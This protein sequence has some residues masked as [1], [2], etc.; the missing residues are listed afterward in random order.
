MVQVAKDPIGTKG[1][2][3]P[4]TSRSPAGT[5]CSCR[6]SITSASRRRIEHE[7][8]RRRL[9]DIRRRYRPPGTGF[10]VRTVAENVAEREARGR[11]P[12]P[13]RGLERRSRREGEPPRRRR[14]CTS[15]R[16]SCASSRPLPRRRGAHGRRQPRSSTRT[17]CSFVDEFSAGSRQKVHYYKGAEPIFD[18][19]SPRPRSTNPAAA[20]ALAFKLA[21]LQSVEPP[22]A[23]RPPAMTGDALVKHAR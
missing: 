13:H 20:L 16:S 11:H 1:A 12:L 17:C 18:A 6:P 8:E 5:W 22:E 15:I 7:K 10:I 3:S 4:R 14:R 19:A 9:R 2:R 23:P 21:L